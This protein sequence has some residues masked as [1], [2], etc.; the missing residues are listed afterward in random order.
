MET[1]EV[2]P[3]RLALLFASVLLVSAYLPHP[4]LGQSLPRS[5]QGWVNVWLQPE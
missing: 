3:R 5:I 2:R 1:I 4:S